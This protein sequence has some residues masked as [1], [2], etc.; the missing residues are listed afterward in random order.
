M[1]NK[2]SSSNIFSSTR[3]SGHSAASDANLS[4]MV[5]QDYFKKI[6][7]RLF[8]LFSFIDTIPVNFYS[9]H[10]II[11]YWRL[12]QLAGPS[13][14][15][16]YGNFWEPNSKYKNTISVVSIFF[17]LVPPN[18]RSESAAII[19]FIYFAIFFIMYIFLIGYSSY[20]RRTAK[21]S[22]IIAP[23]IIVG[24]NGFSHLL[25]PIVSEMIGESIGR[26][27]N[28]TTYY[29]MSVEVVAIVLSFITLVI[30]FI[31]ITWISAVSFCFRPYSL[32]TITSGPQAFFSIYTS[33]VTL[34][35]ALASQ[36][37]KTPQIALTVVSAL[38]YLAGI[39]IVYQPGAFVNRTESSI[40]FGISISS[41]IFMMLVIFYDIFDRY[42][43]MIEIFIYILCLFIFILVGIYVLKKKIHKELIFIDHAYD[44]YESIDQVP[45]LKE[46]FFLSCA[47]TGFVHSHPHCI[48]WTFFKQG[49][50]HFSESKTIWKI[51][52][53]FVAIYPDESNLLSF[54]IHKMQS[55]RMS[56]FIIQ[57]IISQARTIMTQ[58]E[59]S[60][61]I[62]LKYRLSK[63]AKQVRV[64]KSKMRHVWDLAIQSSIYEM[65]TSIN[66]TFISVNKASANFSHLLAQY[67][68]NRFV[69][70]Q[71]SLYV[72]DILGDTS[73]YQQ[74]NE[75]VRNLQRGVMIN[76]DRANIL[77]MHA[78]PSL[79]AQTT[80]LTI[81]CQNN[82]SNNSQSQFMDSE[83]LNDNLDFEE[84]F[85]QEM[86]EQITVIKDMINNISIPAISCI[87]AWIIILFFLFIFTPAIAMI[88][89]S[90][91]FL[92][93]LTYPLE[94][95]YHVSCIR[96]SS[97]LIPLLAQHYILENIPISETNQTAFFPQPNF[98]D[99]Q[100]MMFGGSNETGD[101]L[102]NIIS[103]TSNSA[104]KISLYRT[105]GIN[106]ANIQYVHN[107]IFGETIPYTYFAP[108][109]GYENRTTVTISLQSAIMEMIIQ[110]NPF[111][112][113]ATNS[114]AMTTSILKGPLYNAPII[115]NYSSA[116]LSSMREYLTTKH[117]DIDNIILFAMTFICIV[118]AV[119]IIGLM[120]YQVETL[121]KTKL[122]IYQCLTALPKNVV[123]NVAESLKIID[124]NGG[125]VDD[126]E[127]YD[128][129][130]NTE[131]GDKTGQI[132]GLNDVNKQD[133]NILKVFS[134]ASDLAMVGSS[135]NIIYI[136]LN[137][138]ILACVIG[139]IILICELFPIFSKQLR[140]NAPHLDYVL[141]T[142]AYL[143][144]SVEAL[145][146]LTWFAH[147]YK[148][149]TSAFELSVE[150]SLTAI[151]ERLHYFTDFYHYARYGGNNLDQ[152]SYNG[153]QEAHDVASKSFSCENQTKIPTNFAELYECLSVDLQISLL[154]PF[155][156]YLIAP[157]QTK[158]DDHIDSHSPYL[159]TVWT[160]TIK[161]ID[162]L[163]YPMFREIVDK[164]KNLLNRSI[165]TMTTPAIILLIVCFFTCVLVFI[166]TIKTQD[167]MKFALSLLLHCPPDVVMQTPKIMDVLS[168]DFGSRTREGL[169]KHTEF[170][171]SVVKSIPDSV[172]V[173][174]DRGIVETMNRA[175]ER[176][177][178][179]KKEEFIGTNAREFYSSSKFSSGTEAIFDP[180][181]K[182]LNV[183]YKMTDQD[184]AYL[185]L[186]LLEIPKS[187]STIIIS[188]DQT[189]N[190]SYNALIAAEKEKSDKLLQS[191][192]PP[193]LIPRV[194]N[195]EENISF[196]VQSA[197]ISFMDIVE[198]TPWCAAN[199][200][201]VI[202]S[203]L[204]LMFRE[205]DFSLATHSSLTKIKCIGDCYVAAGG[206]FV[207][208]N[209]PAV[210]AKEMVEFGLEAINNVRKINKIQNMTLRIR[211]GVNTGGP[212][213]AGVLGIDKP[214]FEILGPAINMAQQMEHH[215]VPMEV[216]ISRSTYELIYSGSFNV[217]ERGQIEIKNGQ[218]RTYLV[219]GKK[220]ET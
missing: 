184:Y 157:I 3:E 57:E 75:K 105:F 123:S 25:H 140:D 174:N 195:G 134:S 111:F 89:Y 167:K 96:A 82:S 185:D 210:H 98:G 61:S 2:S 152:P 183:E 60:L 218:V 63:A 148:S 121:K 18:E 28:N 142:V 94:Y 135:E 199:S 216:H 156:A 168:G 22:P 124:K 87:R 15:A 166:A 99:L 29:S 136:V 109:A 181:V 149:N 115:A 163:F 50:D 175:T 10:N 19:E 138:L 37:N 127:E 110:M 130:D 23:L 4:S 53:K 207:E 83:L 39:Y 27:I 162:Q 180:D 202:M 67:P 43:V 153:F 160:V 8:F 125:K 91:E 11:S 220:G 117:D 193:L 192:L 198:F 64:T 72:L 86:S 158:V 155:I 208:V 88:I 95:M 147:Y 68:N 170:F 46:K 103:T 213:V 24:V 209:Q 118:Y 55:S 203:T 141:G 44:N 41:C 116:A 1:I 77:G 100:F 70:R 17:H 14:A 214:T 173:V 9:I 80:S 12:I 204:N 201:Q 159:L 32:M 6:R 197:S 49:S 66:N 45:N 139:I 97:F 219:N 169:M 177:Y 188:R 119:T 31:F 93:S 133:E 112:E 151:D 26:L 92:D 74:W 132:K 59:G 21:M 42:A 211:V 187:Y 56:G 16:P 78:Y 47:I 150:D 84:N 65:D 182:Q 30:N 176:I 200:A 52:G 108:N 126:D 114:A 154:E 186:K 113:N 35:T 104:G 58:R 51:F 33:L 54:I 137:I 165:P 48:D 13:L 73:L 34:I 85:S 106:D 62:D 20:F 146:S 129:D 179:L 144:G 161:A 194:Q 76:N 71:Y 212:I 40:I 145:E 164:I 215:G 101:Q 217:K 190:V 205:F 122:Q 196:S 189:Q 7:N 131:G 36:L 79:P 206:I 102:Y 38:L 172:I 107:I 5:E 81:Q 90:P 69:A 178:G 128:N 171:D 120:I 143:S 191:I